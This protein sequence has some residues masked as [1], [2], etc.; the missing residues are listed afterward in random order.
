[1]IAGHSSTSANRLEWLIGEI[2]RGRAAHV[3]FSYNQETRREKVTFVLESNYHH[4]AGH[5][6]CILGELDAVRCACDSSIT[7]DKGHSASN[8]KTTVEFWLK[9]LSHA[10][11]DGCATF[12]QP[13]GPMS[14]GLVD[15]SISDSCNPPPLVM[16]YPVTEWVE[17]RI[18][19]MH[20]AK[21]EPMS[22][23]QHYQVIESRE[24]QLQE[25][26]T[27]I[28]DVGPCID[29]HTHNMLMGRIDQLWEA[30]NQGASEDTSAAARKYIM[31]LKSISTDFSTI[32]Q[33]ELQI[34][35]AEVRSLKSEDP[36]K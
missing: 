2:Q 15:A 23:T 28:S 30:R 24:D 26:S 33:R 10:E 22:G 5:R 19:E 17:P 16:L 3:S 8:G 27:N 7:T 34:H 13:D 4:Q 14:D 35:R 18:S 31:L 12:V 20:Y 11:A 36:A 6:P 32:V 21:L 9:Q 29:V 25:L 1:M